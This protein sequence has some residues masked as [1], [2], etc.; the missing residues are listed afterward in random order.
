MDSL[1]DTSRTIQAPETFS[2]VLQTTKGALIIDV[3]RALA[4]VGVDRFHTLIQLGY[5]QDVAFFR[6]VPGF[7]AQFG[8]HGDP[9]VNKAWRKARIQDDPVQSRNTEGTI[10]FA[11]SGKHARTTQLFINLRENTRLDAMGFSAFGTVRD[12]SVAQALYSGYGEGAPSGKGPMQGR[13]H[14][15]GNEYLRADFPELDYIQSAKVEG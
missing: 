15:E 4:P 14:R 13:V 11:T 2:A 3:Q 1:L 7:V 6:V 8:I 9:Q 10:C 12:L 5:F